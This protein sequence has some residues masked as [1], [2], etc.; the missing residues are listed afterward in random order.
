MNKME[1]IWTT[2]KAELFFDADWDAINKQI[3]KITSYIN[4]LG[5]QHERDGGAYKQIVNR[6]YVWGRDPDEILRNLDVMWERV[7]GRCKTWGEDDICTDEGE[8]DNDGDQQTLRFNRQVRVSVETVSKALSE[9]RRLLS[10]QSESERRKKEMALFGY[11]CYVDC[12]CHDCNVNEC[13]CVCHDESE[14]DGNSGDWRY[15]N[16]GEGEG[17]GLKAKAVSHCVASEASVSYGEA[18]CGAP[19]DVGVI[20]AKAVRLIETGEVVA[21]AFW[22]DEAKQERES[23]RVQRAA[24]VNGTSDNK[25]WNAVCSNGLSDTVRFHV[26][27]N[28]DYEAE[29]CDDNIY[30]YEY[31]LDGEY[32]Y[33]YRANGVTTYQYSIGIAVK[34]V[35]IHHKFARVIHA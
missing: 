19:S 15:I 25:R 8:S 3:S 18:S 13:G 33:E 10:E 2:K 32:E 17:E 23:H 1:N 24:R 26:S 34:T 16:E 22:C 20:A 28:R 9:T 7:L 31:Y 11:N 29:W 6:T 5:L 14:S 21:S 4:W 12:D 35:L 30:E 27:W